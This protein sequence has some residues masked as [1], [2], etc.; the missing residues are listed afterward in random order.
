MCGIAG[1]YSDDINKFDSVKLLGDMVK[2]IQKR[3]PD[4]TGTYFTKNVGLGH[5]RLSIID[6]S[7]ESN[8]PFHYEGLSLSYNGEIYN[9]IEIKSELLKLNYKFRTVS[10]TEVILAAYKEW[11]KDCVK[12][13]IGMW[14]FVIW[15]ETKKELFCS[16]D[17]FGIKPFLY[18]K[19]ANDFFFASE[20]KAL[21][22]TPL[23]TN[24]INMNQVYR[25]LQLGW[26]NYEDETYF[27]VI[28]NLPPAHNLILRNGEVTL[29]KYWDINNF[30][31][32]VTGSFEDKC[33]EF[34]DLFFDSMKLH[35]RSD[36]PLGVCLSGGLDSSSM[37]SALSII[38]PDKKIKSFTSYYTGLDNKFDERNFVN[39][40]TNK[41]PNLEPFFI[42]P[43][44]ADV[45]ESFEEIFKNF[46]IPLNGSSLISHNFVMYLAKQEGIIVTIDG[47]GGDESMGGYLHTFYRLFADEFSKLRLFKGIS[48]INN[49]KNYHSYS[50]TK[51]LDIY[52]KSFLS[53]LFDENSLYKLEYKY[54][55]NILN[56]K[57]G[58]DLF[59]LVKKDTN[60]TNNFLYHT[61]F[62]T[63]LPSILYCVDFISMLY[64]IE[65]RVP[66]LDHR[67]VELCFTLPNDYKINSSETKYIL[68]KSLESILPPKVAARRDKK[69]FVTPG[70]VH[71][72]RNSM[73]HLL[74]IDYSKL[75]FLDKGKT[76]M[77]LK[78][79][80]NGENRYSNIIW[81]LAMLNKW[82]KTV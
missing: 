5:N 16:R 30:E 2:S 50:L 32:S 21:Q 59:N 76:K 7:P 13:F 35:N 40:V 38:N 73:K 23:Y 72:M 26:L 53:T 80:E 37:A 31:N 8:Q 52:S 51:T 24:E 65:S 44:E 20:I 74:D 43:T 69:G 58:S 79:F 46:S 39:E 25:G 70:E 55:G 12:K 49:Y 75:D 1:F 18:I 61:L 57:N 41:Y 28:K 6:L 47:Q 9:Y 34:Y 77:Y 10:D 60:K 29:E 22:L 63:I 33:K 68:R 67:I 78:D 14:A 42:S 54:N 15:D 27:K 17:R 71:W 4:F 56:H 36:V 11:G 64:S 48:L 3:G 19:K 81:R 62:N 82:M 66:L 45:E